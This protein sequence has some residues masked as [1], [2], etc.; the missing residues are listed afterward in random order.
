MWR[1]RLARWLRL[2]SAAS[3]LALAL[4]VFGPVLMEAVGPRLGG[5]LEGAGKLL[6]SDLLGGSGGG[7][8]AARGF[9]IT[10]RPEP[11]GAELEVDGSSRGQTPTVANVSCREGTEVKLRLSAPGHATWSEKVPCRQGGSLLI[12]PRLQK[13]P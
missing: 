12:R 13:V 1:Y 9:M 10:A 11:A 7:S 8:S 5:S 2:L 4:F 6:P 3:V